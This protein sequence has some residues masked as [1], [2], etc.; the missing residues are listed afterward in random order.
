MAWANS[1]PWLTPRKHSQLSRFERQYP[2]LSGWVYIKWIYA[3]DWVQ[4][5]KQLIESSLLQP[6]QARSSTSAP[7]RRAGRRGRNTS[8]PSTGRT[9]WLSSG[10]DWRWRCGCMTN[11]RRCTPFRLVLEINFKISWRSFIEDWTS[12]GNRFRWSPRHRRW[13][14]EENLCEGI[15]QWQIYSPLNAKFISENSHRFKY[16][17]R[18]NQRKI[19]INKYLFTC[20]S[21]HFSI[22][23]T[24]S[25]IRGWLARKG[26]DFVN[27]STKTL[28]WN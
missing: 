23:P 21:I 18:N 20:K 7:A 13:S 14:W 5:W 11:F 6:R 27:F 28:R 26:K 2:S 4:T 9:R 1:V 24:F 10:R 25:E 17:A 16:F 19:Q 3:S 15:S 22:S 8:P 12:S